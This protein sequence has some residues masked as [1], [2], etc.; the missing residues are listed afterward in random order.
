ML[1]GR[2]FDHA[3]PTTVDSALDAFYQVSALSLQRRKVGRALFAPNA[4]PGG[5]K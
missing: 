5:I 3:F 1:E 4:S 2:D